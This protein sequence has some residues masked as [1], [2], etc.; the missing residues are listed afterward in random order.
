MP[1]QLTVHHDQPYML[2]GLKG[3][4]E[5]AETF[6]VVALAAAACAASLCRRCLFDLRELQSSPDS[7]ERIQL[8]TYG[9]E[10]LRG[11][12]KV[13]VVL[14]PAMQ[15][16]TGEKVAQ[17]LGVRLRNFTDID[18]AKAWIST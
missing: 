9:G 8:A 5:L 3:T 12:D 10:S 1:L 6:G 18:D 14:T 17:K 7:T 4:G 2:L 11:L 15:N 16:G 13:A